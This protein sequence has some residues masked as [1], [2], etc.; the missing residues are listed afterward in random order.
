MAIEKSEPQIEQPVVRAQE[1]A[2]GYLLAEAHG[3]F[4]ARLTQVLEGSTLHMGHVVL[5]SCLFTQNDL[6]QVQLVR[7][8]RVEKS[9]V[10]LFLD[11]LEKDGWI[12][13]RRHPN[14]RRAHLVHLTDSGRKRFA[15]IGKALG[16]AQD[17]MLAAFGRE[18]RTQLESLLLRLI[19]QLR[20]AASSA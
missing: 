17:E 4:R 18:E 2:L 12:Q 13:R 20:D 5:L 11:A 15:V 6:T 1:K 16:R 19:G 7:L 10:V 9:S 14:D 8:A 3:L